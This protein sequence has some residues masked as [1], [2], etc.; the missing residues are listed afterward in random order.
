MRESWRWFGQFD[1]I[2]LDQIRQTGAQAIVSALHEI[3][4]GVV[5]PH[6][7]IAQRKS[8]IEAAGFSWD[9]VESLPVHEA[10]KKGEG[11]LSQLFAN[12]RQS[13]AN[14]AHQGIKTICYNFMPVLDWTRTDLQYPVENGGTCLRFS[15][16]KMAAFEVYMLHLPDAADNYSE[17]TL[18]DA[19]IWF[20]S[21]TSED[22]STLLHAIM[23]GLPGAVDRYNLDELHPVLRRYE[24]ISHSDL[25]S[26]LKRFLE[27]VVP[28]AS[29]LGMKLCIHPDDPPFDILG[30][31][32]IVSSKDDISWLLEAV[33]DNANG[34]T[35]CTGSLGAGAHNDVVEI[36]TCFAHRTHFAHLRNVTKYEDT[37][38]EESEHLGGDV[39]MVSVIELLLT[40]EQ[41][42]AVTIPFRADHG[43][44]LLSDKTM[45]FQPGYTLIG[46]L[47][48]LAELRGIIASSSRRF[49]I[50]T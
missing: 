12:Y 26:N 9:V 2:P 41:E 42:R 6:E 44:S 10:I 18:S 47:R 14:L 16:V 5:W 29:E 39:D 15:A 33:D 22:K 11:D 25:R 8:E 19:K 35:F 46:R 7:A 24:G 28:T 38:F 37:S 31:P 49:D 32:R 21:A 1:T 13:L 43:H 20:D 17:T 30:L 45:T 34:L 23:S 3:P 40:S 36:A 50:A 4:Y 27:E 48:G